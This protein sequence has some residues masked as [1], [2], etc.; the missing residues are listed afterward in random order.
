MSFRTAYRA[1][2]RVLIGEH[3]RMVEAMLSAGVL[4]LGDPTPHFPVAFL[5]AS[6]YDY[7]RLSAREE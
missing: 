6:I 1:W 5:L 2:Y 3:A 7:A 4:Y